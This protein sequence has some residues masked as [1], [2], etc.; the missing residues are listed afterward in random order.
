LLEGDFMPG[1]LKTF[2]NAIFGSTTP[3]DSNGGNRP[4]T[5]LEPTTPAP[6]NT[7]SGLSAHD[8]GFAIGT[9]GGDITRAAEFQYILSRV[10]PPGQKPT[11]EQIG[12]I[13]GMMGGGMTQAVIIDALL[14]KS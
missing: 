7:T 5:P 11:T 10:L 2:L 13:V 12:M 3:S 4:L 14:N 1:K 9:A 8:I 6:A